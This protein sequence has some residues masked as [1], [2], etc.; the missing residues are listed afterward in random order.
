MSQTH[1]TA[2]TILRGLSL[3][4]LAGFGAF[5]QNPAPPRPQEKP[6]ALVGATIHPVS[7]KPIVNGVIVFDKGIIQAV[8][9][10][11]TPFDKRNTEIIDVAGKHIYPGSIAPATTVGLQEIASVRATLDY[12]ETGEINPNVRALI[13]YNTD[14]EVIPTL[15]SSGILIA[16]ATPS[17]GLISG[18]SS[19]FQTD[20]WNWEDAVLRQDDGVWLNW[21][22]YVSRTFNQSD[23]SSALKRNEGRQQ[24]IDQLEQFFL[25]ASSYAGQ[26]SPDPVNLRL[27]AMKGVLE[28]NANLYIRAQLAKDIVEAV[29]FAQRHKVAKVVIVGGNEA[30]KVADFLS[31]NKIPVILNEL[32]RLPDHQDD[33]VFHPYAL[34]GK[35]LAAG[36]EVAMSYAA[37]WW[38]VRNLNYQAGTAA[39]FSEHLQPEEALKLVTLFP[40]KIL[41]IDRFVGS[42]E[43]GKHATLVVTRGDILDMKTNIVERAFIRGANVSLD[44]KQKRLYE[45]YKEKYGQKE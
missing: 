36:V 33:E 40:A 34:P 14:S 28:G 32:H 8:G 15:R 3:C 38:R 16:Q 29:R 11:D 22:P 17:G 43:V 20:G 18:T 10:I 31:E 45:K 21:P 5:A 26:A 19:V 27:H 44:D 13:A 12:N 24:V 4:L 23:F 35:L 1:S 25:D 41:G 6:V 30:D 2:A 42:L 9:G 7:G 39:G 37:E